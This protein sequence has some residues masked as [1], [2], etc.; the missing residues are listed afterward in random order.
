VLAAVVVVGDHLELDLQQQ[1]HLLVDD[2]VDW[3]C[4]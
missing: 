1:R 3:T 2:G 4:G